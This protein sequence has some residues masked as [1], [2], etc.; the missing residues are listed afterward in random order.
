MPCARCALRGRVLV[1]FLVRDS[2][3]ARV[4]APEFLALCEKPFAASPEEVAAMYAAAD[5]A[6]IGVSISI[7]INIGVCIV[8]ELFL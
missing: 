3:S 6:G 5:E 1:G 4:S 8:R 2:L 7:D